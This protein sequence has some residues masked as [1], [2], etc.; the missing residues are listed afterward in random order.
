[1][2]EFQFLLPK[3]QHGNSDQKRTDETH[4]QFDHGR[5]G[6]VVRLLRNQN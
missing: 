3:L 5:P 2:L 1:V 6:S 4:Q